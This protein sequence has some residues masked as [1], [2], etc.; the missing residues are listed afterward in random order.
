[1]TV[2]FTAN[3]HDEE[4]MV[5]AICQQ[6]EVVSQGETE[7]LALANIRE[8]VALYFDLPVEMVVVLRGKYGEQ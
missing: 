3:L 5:V 7:Q 1:M 8:A 2:V 6:V 4:D